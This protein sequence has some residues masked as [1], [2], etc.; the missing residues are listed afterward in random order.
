MKRKLRFKSLAALCLLGS[1][2]FLGCPP[3]EECNQS[4]SCPA[5]NRCI[6][7]RGVGRCEPEV[8]VEV[9]ED[10]D[11]LLYTNMLLEERSEWGRDGVLSVQ[12]QSTG[13]IN[14]AK[15]ELWAGAQAGTRVLCPLS[16]PTARPEVTVGCFEIQLAALPDLP[17]GEYALNLTANLV[18][19]AGE[20]KS[21]TQNFN[22]RISRALWTLPLTGNSGVMTREGLL[23]FLSQ[24]RLIALNA[25]GEEVWSAALSNPGKKLLLGNNR[26]TDLVVGT[27]M[28]ANATTEGLW[29]VE[30][31]TG[32]VLTSCALTPSGGSDLVLL[33]S[34]PNKSLIV[35]R[36]VS[37]GTTPATYTLEAYYLTQVTASMSSPW[38]FYVRA[39]M[40]EALPSGSTNMLVRQTPEGATRVFV[41]DGAHSWCAV[42]WTYTGGWSRGCVEVGAES[43]QIQLQLH[44]LGTEFLWAS[45]LYISGGRQG[46]ATCLQISAQH[47]TNSLGIICDST[48]A[49]HYGSM[50]ALLVDVGDQLIAQKS[51]EVPKIQRYSAN[52]TLLFERTGGLG[53]STTALMEGGSLLS[54]GVSCLKP[55][56]SDCWEGAIPIPG[57][58]E[59][60]GIFPSSATRSMMVFAYENSISAFLVDTSGLK[61]DAPWPIWGHDL[62]RTYNVSVP[63]D[64]CWDGP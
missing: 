10:P 52:N 30:A 17:H 48:P 7:E 38:V 22:V 62:C 49:S 40:P 41:G 42:D 14:W 43:P 29:V 25:R 24:Q 6:I 35:G 23:L 58:K 12:V 31:K 46:A 34:G 2:F 26:G 39:R 8:E 13:N 21:H 20:S 1:V 37:L 50:S 61:K 64:N 5:G 27:C 11:F 55:D 18:N 4:Q 15:A 3:P 16:F 36:R 47:A 56:F 54:S 28:P 9:E 45:Y 51:A 53:E 63:V 19:K 33:Q 32:K 60:L 57:G 59:L 44:L